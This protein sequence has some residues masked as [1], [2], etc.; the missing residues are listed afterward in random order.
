[1][2]RDNF[3][4]Y[5][6]RSEKEM[7][8]YFYYFILLLTA[9]LVY[10][11]KINVS[12]TDDDG[13]DG[14]F[15]HDPQPVN[16]EADVS[17][18]PTL[19]WAYN[20]NNNAIFFELYLDTVSPPANSM[21]QIYGNNYSV[22]MPLKGNTT[23]YWKVKGFVENEIYESTIWNFRTKNEII[24]TLGLTAYYPFNG[25]A[26][27]LSGN[28]LNG[29]VFDASLTDSRFGEFGKAYFFDGIGSYIHVNNNTLLNPASG[30]TISAWFCLF[31]NSNSGSIVSK[32]SENST[33]MY[34][35]KFNA[36]TQT[37]DIRLIL[38]DNS[39]I[40]LSI[41]NSWQ[42]SR[43]YNVTGT[44]DRSYLNVYLDGNPSGSLYYPGALGSNFEDLYIGKNQ[45]GQ[46][47]YGKLD[48]I[49]VYERALNETE[50]QQLYHEGG[51]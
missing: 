5:I 23:Y 7:K 21:G 2:L 38:S 18:T 9:M 20:S 41:Y 44:F 26:N 6:L 37:I 4:N 35:L 39:Q 47:F 8:K 12:D 24:P 11:C 1:M 40:N 50:I 28:G 48:D 42:I 25:N 51:W 46:Y 30:I 45:E 43:W 16:G 27:D 22:T 3:F 13:G 32:G 19:N 49:R 14:E 31:S 10:S 36:Q 33:G 15:F 17:L 29:T 34:G